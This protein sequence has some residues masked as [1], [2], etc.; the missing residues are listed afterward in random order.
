MNGGKWWGSMC[1]PD[2]RRW[3]VDAGY[4]SKNS[5]KK[6]EELAGLSSW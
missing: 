5:L 1:S 2:A 6:G 4:F 3:I